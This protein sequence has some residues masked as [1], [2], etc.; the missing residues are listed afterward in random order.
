MATFRDPGRAPAWLAIAAMALNALWPLLANAKPAVPA[1]PS[2]ICSA[3]GLKH[4]GGEPANAPDRGSHPS[5]CTLCPFNAERGA[6]IPCLAI[7]PF[8]RSATA[9]P[10]PEFTGTFRLESQLDLTARPR[11]PPLLS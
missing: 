7:P 1:L 3:T 6:A 9:D 4:A 11:A 2:E 5:H 10:R 8:A